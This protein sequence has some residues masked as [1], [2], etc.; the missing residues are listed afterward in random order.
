[1]NL[2]CEEVSSIALLLDLDLV[3]VCDRVCDRVR[4]LGL[5]RLC[6]FVLVRVWVLLI[7]IT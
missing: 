1:M 5:V 2:F 6:D 7:I 3:G 4:D